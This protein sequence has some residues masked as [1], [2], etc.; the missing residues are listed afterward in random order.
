MA[1]DDAKVS[2]YA[3][4]VADDDA[5]VSDYATQVADDD[6]MMLSRLIMLHWWLMML[7]R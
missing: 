2:D 4:Q 6:V 7:H 1:D 3:T 5:K